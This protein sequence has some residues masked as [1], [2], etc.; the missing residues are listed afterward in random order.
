V[1]NL[2]SVAA[3]DGGATEKLQRAFAASAEK[4]AA[5]QKTRIALR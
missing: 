5:T 2:R 1:K 4:L 3:S